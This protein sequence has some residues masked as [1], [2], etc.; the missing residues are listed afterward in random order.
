VEGPAVPSIPITN[1]EWKR[2]SLLCH[3]DRSAAQWRDLQCALTLPQFSLS[4]SNLKQKCHPDRS[5]G[6]CCSLDPNNQCRMEAP[7]SPLSS[8][9]ER[10]AVE[11]SAVR[12]RPTQILPLNPQ[13]ECPSQPHSTRHT[14]IPSLNPKTGSRM[15]PTNPFRLEGEP[16][17]KLQLT[18]PGIS[19]ALDIVYLTIP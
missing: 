8:R 3:P 10:S 7:L 12:P 19:A 9:P 1:V 5:G 11:G 16:G 2:H 15:D 17:D 13:T 14:R 6:T 4:T 18:H